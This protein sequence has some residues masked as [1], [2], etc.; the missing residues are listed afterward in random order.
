LWTPGQAASAAC[1]VPRALAA[2]IPSPVFIDPLP[3]QSG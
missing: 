3:M 2:A 1:A